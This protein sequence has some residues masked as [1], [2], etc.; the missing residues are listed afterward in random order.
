MSFLPAVRSF[1]RLLWGLLL[2]S[3]LI[4]LESAAAAQ[5]PALTSTPQ[6]QATPDQDDATL[7]DVCFVGKTGYAVGDRGTIWKST[8]AGQS[9]TFVPMSPETAD[10]SWRSVCFLTNFVGWVAGGRV[11][12]Y[13][14]IPEGVLYVTQDGGTT[15]EPL[16]DQLPYLKTIRMFDLESGAALAEPSR[17]YPSGLLQTSDGGRTWTAGNA[18]RTV[19]WNAAAFVAPDAGIL[20]GPLG[21]KAG[22]ARGQIVPPTLPAS[23]LRNI[24]GVSADRSGRCWIAGDGALL[25]T[26][27][28]AGASWGPPET[29]L[30]AALADF[31]RFQ[32]VT[33]Q[34]THVWVAGSPGSIIWHS[35]DSGT[36]WDVQRTGDP[37]P[38]HAIQF[39]SESTGCAVGSLGRISITQDGGATWTTTRGQNRRL[40]LLALHAH[41]ERMSIPLI[42]R[43]ASEEGYR[44]GVSLFS[45]QDVGPDAHTAQGQGI[46]LHSVVQSAGGNE[47]VTGWRL[48]LAVPGIARQRDRLL[49]DWSLL[50]DR[51][52]AEVVLTELVGQIRMWRPSAIVVDEP[53]P[54]DAAS[55]FLRQ[56]IEAAIA[57]AADPAAFPAQAKA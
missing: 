36:S 48:P 4:V 51:R 11:R 25:L 16:T 19:H 27:D 26:S 50:T 29:T 39:S 57:Q 3:S 35:A 41:P 52:F 56:A 24:H 7:H 15:W 20:V 46:E 9:W 5:S 49:E 37:N 30:P 32:T 42:A 8:D 40:A 55:L 13:E 45:R 33:Q 1:R 53:L 2:T 6:I 34:G 38:I 28:N 54:D 18:T 21:E 17:K 10:V 31:M 43:Q 22:V 23:G 47:I 44:C 14:Q 12:P